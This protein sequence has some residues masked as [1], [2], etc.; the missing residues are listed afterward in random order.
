MIP[1]FH[2]L[3]AAGVALKAESPWEE[4]VATDVGWLAYL[5]N[6]IF[7]AAIVVTAVTLWARTATR[8]MQLVPGGQQ[9]LFEA[10]VEALYVTVEGIVGRHMAKKAFSLL[11]TIFIFILVANWFA[12]LPGVGS[13]GWGPK[14]GFLTVK[15]ATVPLLRPATADLNM[16]LGIAAFFMIL[17]LWWT[18]REV[19]IVGFLDHT[20]GVKGGVQGAMFFVLAPIFLFVGVIEVISTIFR[21]ISLSLRL[22][23]NVFAGETLLV[24]MITLGKQL[25]MP[26]LVSGL[27]AILVPVPF[28]FLEL[29][30]GLL[31]AGVFM[32]LC[33]VYLQLSTTHDEGH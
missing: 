5:T 28:Y 21:P 8:K 27:M 32:L 15:E 22:F 3:L 31:Q 18:L 12:L 25:G 13:I 1:H 11:A 16:T 2:P 7:V 24:S 9:N 19:G 17:W 20:F 14:E 30:I 4:L 33:A 10:I 26:P 29:L 23:G 6:S